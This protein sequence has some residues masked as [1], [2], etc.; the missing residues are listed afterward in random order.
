MWI[1]V[2]SHVNVSTATPLCR[3]AKDVESIDYVVNKTLASLE[4]YSY[5][6]NLVDTPYRIVYVANWFHNVT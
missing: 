5:D 2:V 1:G 6:P 4:G 3:T